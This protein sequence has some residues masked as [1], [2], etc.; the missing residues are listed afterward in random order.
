MHLQ[1]YN[2]QGLV[3]HKPQIIYLAL[4]PSDMRFKIA[5]IHG[6]IGNCDINRISLQG[7]IERE[8]KCWYWYDHKKVDSVL[9]KGLMKAFVPSNY[10]GVSEKKRAEHKCML[11][12][13]IFFCW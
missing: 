7:Y 11:D 13:S 5:S 8:F 10:F 6:K 2:W 12:F 4:N 9:I 1:T 3:F